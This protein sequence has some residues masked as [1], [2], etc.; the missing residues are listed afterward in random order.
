MRLCLF[1]VS[2]T[3]GKEC[4]KAI[5]FFNESNKLYFDLHG[6]IDEENFDKNNE[7]LK[8]LNDVSCN[9]FKSLRAKT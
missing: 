7:N 6:K 4:K 9:L 1:L 3:S 8:Y 5:V 2:V